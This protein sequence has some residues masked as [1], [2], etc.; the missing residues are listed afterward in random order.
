M[1][2]MLAASAALVIS[3]C[4]TPIAWRSNPPHAVASNEYFTAE[5]LPICK[6]GSMG[7][8]GG[9]DAFTLKVTN[10]TS[11]NIEINWNKTAYI[12]NGQTSGGFMYEGVSYRDRAAQKSPDILFANSSMTKDIWPNNLV[13][14]LSGAYGWIHLRMTEGEN[15]IYLSTT[16]D[17]KE[18]SEKLTVNLLS[19]PQK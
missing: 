16:I 18:V 4:A 14:F 7:S 1:S 5:A 10:K 13:T 19:S 3:A 2:R 6:N 8:S 17:G 12:S 11:K 9:C 15:G